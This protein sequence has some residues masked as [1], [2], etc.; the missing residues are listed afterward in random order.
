VKGRGLS[1]REWD[2]IVHAFI[3]WLAGL[4]PSFGYRHYHYHLQREFP[5]FI[6]YIGTL[7][8]PFCKQ[9]FRSASGF[10]THMRRQHYFDIIHYLEMKR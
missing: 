7:K 8:C 4:T 2:K 6:E 9:Q 5:E 10:V 3:R 1:I